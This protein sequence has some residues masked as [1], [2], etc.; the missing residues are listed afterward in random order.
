MIKTIVA[1]FWLG[2]ICALISTPLNII[3]KGGY[4]GNIWGDTLV[5]MLRWYDAPP[6]AAALAG[7]MIVEILD[8]QVCMLLALFI[9]Y[10]V[11]KLKKNKGAP[12]QTLTVIL[13]V[14]FLYG[15]VICPLDV[16]AEDVNVLDDN[17]VAEI[18]NNTNGMVSSEANVICETEDG[19]I[20]IGSYA[21]LSRYDGNQFEF[22]REGG[23]VNVV[24]MME[25]SKGRLWIGINDAGIAR[26][27]DGKYTYFNEEDGLPTNSVRCFAEDEDGTVYVGTSEKICRFDP[28]DNIDVLPH[29]INFTVD[30]EIYDGKL[31]VIDN[32]GGLYAIDGDQTLT[33]SESGY[34]FY[35]LACTSDGL[36]VGTETGEL[37]TAEISDGGI[38]LSEEKNVPADKISA[39]FE[40]SRGYIWIS[41][42]SGLGY[43]DCDGQYIPMNIDGFNESINSIFEDYQGNI[44]FASQHY[45]VM[46]LAESPFVNAFERIGA[47]SQVVNAVTM[48]RGNYFCGTDKGMVVFNK[49]G[50]NSEY[51]VLEE[52]TDGTRVRCIYTDSAGGLWLCT[53]NGLINY[54]AAGEIKQYNTGNCG[55]TSDRFRCM[56]ELSD[57]TFAIGT[58]DGINF[59]KDDRLAGTIT[60][61]DGMGNTQILSVA[62]G[63]DGSVWAGSDGSGIYVINDGRI[64]EKYSTENGLP[65]DVILRIIP[66]EDKYLVVTSNSLCCID[67]NGS[68]RKLESFPYFNNYDIMLCGD[69]AYV[70][71]SAGLYEIKLADLCDDNCSRIRLYSAGEGLFSGLTANSWNYISE[72]GELYLC[73]NSGV[74]V[75]DRNAV[76]NDTDMKYGIVSLECDD[77]RIIPADDTFNIPDNAKNISVYASVRNFAFT[78]AKVRFYV[79]E[80]EEAPKLY[81]WNEIEPIRMYKPENGEYHI[82]L[83]VL[84]SSGGKVLQETVYTVK[85][86]VKPWGTSIYRVYLVAVCTDILLL[87]II[88]I[89]SLILIILRKNELE[90]LRGQ[91]ENTIGK[92]TDELIMQQKEMKSLLIQTVTA[93]SEAVDAKDRYTSGHSRRVA[94]Y[95]RMIAERMGKS[96]EEQD[97]IY[98]AG[99]LHDIGKIRIPVE[100]INKAS[101]LTDEEY[102]I[103][104]IH[105]ITGYNIL[106]GISGNKL[107]AICAKYHHERY[108]GKGY[109]NG[110]SG[111]KIPEAAR[112]LGVADS[113]DA[114]TSNR[115]YRKALPQAVVR[116]E[117]EK[118]RGTQFDPKIADVMLEMIDEDKD[119]TMKQADEIHRRVLIVDDEVINHKLIA[120]I[121]S[122]EPAYKIV[123][124]R[125][126]TDAIK[127]LEQMSF[128]LILL[129]VRM[130]GMDGIETLK[131]IRENYNIPVVFMT[132]DKELELA[133]EF[134]EL[135]C[136]DYITKPFLPLL[137]KEVIHNMT[138]RTTI[139]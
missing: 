137:I 106:R 72:N 34:F 93:L 8:K 110:L 23:L 56:A 22:I 104:K 96:R 129:D 52:M 69:T 58:A 40:D 75:F 101:K 1:S 134:A 68:I 133:G 97:E 38:A 4:S 14:C 70:T 32:N 83:Q 113:Y 74:M 13:A 105:S 59:I 139:E 112:I 62:E 125:S 123:S 15:A 60:G 35:C 84:D 115:S 126:G 36:L 50:L 66:C 85:T 7:E 67:E 102:N 25:D 31:F 92:Q 11:S 108:D 88:S 29:D 28:D 63:Y 132:G 45:G 76:N 19:Y 6:N 3:I 90:T 82:C 116:G 107:I 87:M 78:D 117:I 16:S 47:E 2:I 73:S 136:D 95:S 5:D 33:P 48:Y 122:D 41:L 128:D 98:R 135:G 118:G 20:W 81:S 17:F 9:I 49:S 54:T 39:V 114:M 57:G 55:V 65:S 138:E 30:M 86:D 71:C 79:R 99:L 10:I 18:Y 77:E 53:Y 89:V 100:I 61:E 80:L 130:P 12:K 43:I 26:Y 51:D 21:G 24:S 124:V 119:Y 120:E 37:F 64:T 42:G 127:A 111:E 46:K 109:P 44:W 27:E 94:E 91:L 121:M 103:I 131:A